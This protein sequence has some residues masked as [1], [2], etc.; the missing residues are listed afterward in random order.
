MW[1]PIVVRWITW[2]GDQ[3]TDAAQSDDPLTYTA[4]GGATVLARV[5]QVRTRAAW[6]SIRE[7][8][9]CALC[10][11]SLAPRPARLCIGNP[12]ERRQAAVRND[13]TALV[14]PGDALFTGDRALPRRA[15]DAGGEVISMPPCLFR[16]ENH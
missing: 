8:A 1:E 3:F 12:N 16:M 11:A 15:A 14:F 5:N 7:D 2:G 4:P 9:S 13:R 6:Y 10:D